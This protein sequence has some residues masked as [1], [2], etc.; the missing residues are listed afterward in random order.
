MF[1]MFRVSAFHSIET[2]RF[3]I[4][5]NQGHITKFFISLQILVLL[6]TL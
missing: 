6:V 1:A 2:F 3:D 4:V 5:T